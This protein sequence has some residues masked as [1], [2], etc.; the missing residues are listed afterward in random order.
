MR[1]GKMLMAMVASLEDAAMNRRRPLMNL[2]IV[3][4]DAAW[5]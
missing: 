2:S 3:F 4:F 1:K 5:G